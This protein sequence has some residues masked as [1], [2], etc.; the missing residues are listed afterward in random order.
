LLIERAGCLGGASTL[1]NVVTY[2]GL[3]TWAIRR[4]RRWP[5]SPKR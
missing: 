3:Y 2:C 4:D 5:A 1:R